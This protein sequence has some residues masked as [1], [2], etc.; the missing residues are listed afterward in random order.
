MFLL[1]LDAPGSSKCVRRMGSMPG[2]KADL[3]YEINRIRALP[4]TVV[5]GE[6]GYSD[7]NSPRYTARILNAVGI[8]KI[9][10]FFTNDTHEN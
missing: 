5:Y 2:W 6:A 1:E 3:R 10:G 4:H 9:R 7:A 8:R